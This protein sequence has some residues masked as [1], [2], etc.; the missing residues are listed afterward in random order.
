[1]EPDYDDDDLINDYIEEEEMEPPSD[2]EADEGINDETN[3][4]RP[5][6]T[7]TGSQVAETTWDNDIH[8]R[9][10]AADDEDD[11]NDGVG[12][13]SSS[14]RRLFMSTTHRDL[15]SFER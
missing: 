4:A 9:S 15:Y 12:S 1:M 10:E 2:V 11:D 14:S 7:R 3:A 6:A 8:S 5:G 13:P